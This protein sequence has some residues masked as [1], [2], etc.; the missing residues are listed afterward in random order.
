MAQKLAP[1]A[2][3]PADTAPED[4]T[5]FPEADRCIM[6]FEGSQTY[7]SY[8]QHCITKWEVNAVHALAAPT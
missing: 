5:E 2:G 7:K 3:E 1:K 4:D 8:W 6:I